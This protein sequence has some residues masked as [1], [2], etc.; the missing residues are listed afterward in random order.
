V[1]VPN[2]NGIPADL[3]KGV[4]VNMS[5]ADRVA[6]PPNLLVRLLDNESVLLN[7]ETER[8]FGVDETGTRMWQLVTAATSIDAA[9]QQLCDEYDVEP[10]LL[11][12]NLAELLSRLIDNG[13][14]Q[15]VSSD[16]GTRTPRRGGFSCAGS[17]SCL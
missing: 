3:A 10:E 13:L 9:F 6:V 4:A 16:V 7:L 14:L 12:A 15:I 17:R 2:R 1:E 5:F 11:R 8:Y